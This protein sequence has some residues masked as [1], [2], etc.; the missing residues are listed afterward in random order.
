ML[1][2]LV[3]HGPHFRHYSLMTSD[4]S[5]NLQWNCSGLGFK[6]ELELPLSSLNSSRGQNADIMVDSVEDVTA[7]FPLQEKWWAGR[8]TFYYTEKHRCLS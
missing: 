6:L 5:V 1:H 7:P 8:L 2:T 4:L 3:V